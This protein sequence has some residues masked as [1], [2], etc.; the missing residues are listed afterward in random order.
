VYAVI[1]AG[2]KQYKVTKGDVLEIE[3]VGDGS[4]EV[5]FVPL[6]VVDDKGK[7]RSRKADLAD[8]RVTAKVLGD[9]KGP[10]VDIFKYRN[11]TGY[12]RH[13]GHRQR[14]TSIQIADIKLTAGRSKSTASKSTAPKSTTSKS[15]ASK[16]TASKSTASKSRAAKS[17]GKS[18]EAK[19]PSKEVKDGS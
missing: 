11:K 3:H 4:D 7:S 14:Y 6:L 15:T 5:E 2:G 1:R 16:S 17:T 18:D 9:T 8:A 10:K 19:A 12:R 13:T